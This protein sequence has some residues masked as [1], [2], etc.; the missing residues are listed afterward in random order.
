MS[1]I[2]IFKDPQ[3]PSP[4]TGLSPPNRPLAAVGPPSSGSVVAAAAGQPAATPPTPIPAPPGTLARGTGADGSSASLRARSL[5]RDAALVGSPGGSGMPAAANGP[6]SRA[7]SV[8]Q[9]PPYA[10]LQP[11]PRPDILGSLATIKAMPDLV[12]HRIGERGQIAPPTCSRI[13]RAVVEVLLEF[14]AAAGL[15][16]VC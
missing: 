10:R 16:R 11:T 2:N 3:A 1:R 14:S 6:R 15:A 8:N 5:E 13:R 9:S 7:A 12:H 4:A